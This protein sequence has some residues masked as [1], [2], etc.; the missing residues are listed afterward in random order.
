MVSVRNSS[1]SQLVN[2]D[3]Y[4]SW[5]SR[6]ALCRMRQQR[7]TASAKRGS[8]ESRK[9]KSVDMIWSSLVEQERS[10]RTDLVTGLRL[11]AGEGKLQ[12]PSPLFQGGDDR[13]HLSV[14]KLIHVPGR[15]LLC[16]RIRLKQNPR[17]NVGRLEQK[18]L[19]T[20]LGILLDTDLAGKER[21][22]GES[23]PDDQRQRPDRMRS[24]FPRR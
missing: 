18:F 9:N 2:W 24:Q 17:H 16:F 12:V 13:V 23:A 1:T 14:G 8:S 5:Y 10:G 22:D 19:A 3:R 15:Q 21:K 7:T 4:A 20:Q 6:Y 11:R